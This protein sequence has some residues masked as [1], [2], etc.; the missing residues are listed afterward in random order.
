MVFSSK[1]WINQYRALS[2]LILTISAL[3][4]VACEDRSSTNSMTSGAEVDDGFGGTINGSNSGM[5]AGENGGEQAGMNAGGSAGVTAGHAA[6]VS[7]GVSAGESAGATAGASARPPVDLARGAELYQEYCG[8]CHGEQGEGYLADNAN[9]LSNQDFLSVATDEF[10]TLAIIHGRPGTPMSPWGDVKGGP[11]TSDMTRDIVAFI[12]QWQTVDSIEHPAPELEGN[13]QR[14]L[15]LYR[16]ACAGCH[17]ELGEGISAVS[18]NNPWFLHTVSDGMIAHAIEIGRAGTAMGAY[19]PPLVNAQGLA[20]LV[21]LIRSWERPVDTD[22]PPPFTPQVDQAPLNP[23]GPEPMF[24]LREDRYVSATQ[25]YNA[26]EM[27]ARF[28]LI[29]A[30]P[31]ADYL[32]EHIAGAISLPFYDVDQYADQ[33]PQD[34]FTVTYCGCPHAVSGQAADALSARGF[35]RVAILDEGFYE[36]R[37]TF[38]YP[39]TTGTQP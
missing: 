34:A 4:C 5:T 36:W 12:R 18:L 24:E 9:A 11:L 33:L 15:P 17:G 7:A 16:A 1:L 26:M 35:N 10:L 28:T 31:A 22:P 29:D 27:G 38:A 20:D 23:E 3:M 14:G 25:V 6:G 30:R 21:A 2:S 13:A 32:D 37:D 8:F 19:G 39:I